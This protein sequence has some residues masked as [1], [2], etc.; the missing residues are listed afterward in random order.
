MG[1][2]RT[3]KC[4]HLP[5]QPAALKRMQHSQARREK[6]VRSVKTGKERVSVLQGLLWEVNV[7]SNHF[8]PP[9]GITTPLCSSSHVI[10]FLQ[11][12]SRCANV[13]I[14]SR[15][16][17]SQIGVVDTVGSCYASQKSGSESTDRSDVGDDFW[18][19]SSLRVSPCGDEREGGGQISTDGQRAGKSH[20]YKL[21][22]LTQEPTLL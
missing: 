19:S 5:I 22:R 1:L 17:H 2:E 9:W 4:R 12:D 10:L 15:A 14:G 3:E 6:S 18:S 7:S 8:L 21:K 16:V 13:G 20:F 11:R